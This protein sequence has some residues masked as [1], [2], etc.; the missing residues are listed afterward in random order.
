MENSSVLHEN[1]GS[2]IPFKGVDGR[3]VHPG[4]EIH[5]IAAPCDKY[6]HTTVIA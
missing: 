2:V 3:E 6:L 4:F 1:C 5:P